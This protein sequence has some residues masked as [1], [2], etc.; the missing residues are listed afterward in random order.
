MTS[1][2]EDAELVRAGR[3]GLGDNSAKTSRAP[4]GLAERALRNVKADRERF[5]VR[6]A[7]AQ[8]IVR[9]LPYGT[10]S[11]VRVAL[12]RLAGLSKI[13]RTAILAGPLDLVGDG[14]I[15]PRLA[16]GDYTF[17]NW[18]CYI[19]LSAPVTIGDRVG[20]GN[21]LTVVTSSHRLGPRQQRMSSLTR[22]PVVIGN[23]VWIGANV[24]ILP[25]VTVGDGAFLTAGAV[26]TK[27][28][29]PNAQMAGNHAQVVGWID[30][31]T[32][33]V[34]RVEKSTS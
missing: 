3:A 1:P 32:G 24:V 5:H 17:I 14:D 19:E 11:P 8:W 18:P 12:Y 26:I 31:E 29:P 15:Y 9:K 20:I 13:S 33:K 25:G 7:V 28:V 30:P 4:R 22:R 21:H 10:L 34:T 2:Q 6:L 27:D 23:G 16:I